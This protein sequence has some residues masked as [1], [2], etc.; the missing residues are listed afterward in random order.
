MRTEKRVTDRSLDAPL[1]QT[2]RCSVCGREMTPPQSILSKDGTSFCDACY[3]DR[4]FEGTISHH[5]QA[6]DPRNG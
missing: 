2:H 6:P 4:F 1:K 3:R 5:R